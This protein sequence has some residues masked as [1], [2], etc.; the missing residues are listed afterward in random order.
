MACQMCKTRP[1]FNSMCKSCF[2]SYFVKKVRKDIRLN[3]LFRRNDAI[4]VKEAKDAPSFAAKWF[5]SN[6]QMPLKISK[7]GRQIIGTSIERECSEFLCSMFMNKALKN[8]KNTIK[9]LSNMSEDEI[10]AFAKLKGYKGKATK[11]DDIM[12]MVENIEI[13]HS[14]TR[15]ALLKSVEFLKKL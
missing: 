12:Q 4:H 2:D 15:A 10:F 7:K 11:K 6:M 13:K 5:I 1:Y 8:Q 9:L 3:D 14:T